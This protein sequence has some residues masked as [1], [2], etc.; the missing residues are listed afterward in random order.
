MVGSAWP[1][2]RSTGARATRQ[3]RTTSSSTR[4]R[5]PAVRSRSSRRTRSG[6]TLRNFGTEEQK[7]EFLPKILRRATMFFSIGYSEP[8][9]GSD[10][11]SLQTKAVKDGDE[12]V[13][14]G[15]K[16]YTSLAWDADYVWLAART[17]P[18]AKAHKGITIFLVPTDGSGVLDHPV[19]HDGHDQHDRHLLRR[20]AGAR[21]SAVVGEVNGG[22]NLIT[23]QLNQE[24]VS[25]CA[26][27]GITNTVNQI[28]DWCKRDRASRR[29][30]GDR[31][32]VGAGEAGGDAGPRALPRPPQ[33]E[34][35]LQPA[36][37]RR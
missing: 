25:L 2:P 37:R 33:L 32:G 6:P 7:N 3:W 5:R 23:N 9:A 19:H 8:G 20:R 12:W 31:P 15:Q 24:R 30:S 10:L 26:A 36:D 18:E 28:I 1:G 35:G 29:W 4:P 21:E 27:G 34:G 17:D 13:I 16:L 22:W 14:N 11:A